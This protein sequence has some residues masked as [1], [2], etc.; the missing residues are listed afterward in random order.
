MIY[1]IEGQGH[2]PALLHAGRSSP[3][4]IVV[5]GLLLAATDEARLLWKQSTLPAPQMTALRNASPVSM[6]VD[7]VSGHL[8]HKPKCTRNSSIWKRR[9]FRQCPIR[10]ASIWSA[11]TPTPSAA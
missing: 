6:Q 8:S 9:R 4:S 11:S 2:P 5:R 10:T 3:R 7:P 1:H